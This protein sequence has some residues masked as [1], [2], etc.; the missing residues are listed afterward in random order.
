MKKWLSAILLVLVLVMSASVPVPAYLADIKTDASADA[1]TDASADAKTAVEYLAGNPDEV[2]V[3]ILYTNDAH[4]YYQSNIGYDGLAL[5]K[6]ELESLYDNVL[7]ID[8]GDA[9]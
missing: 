7:L 8:A 2:A 5:Y 6:K 3:V 1:K 9:I 4:T